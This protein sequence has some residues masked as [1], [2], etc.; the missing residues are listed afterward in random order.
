MAS[1]T[2]TNL[3]NI[4]SNSTTTPMAS[5]VNTTAFDVLI[6]LMALLV[7]LLCLLIIG[8]VLRRI[9]R[10]NKSNRPANRAVSLN[11]L[12]SDKG[13]KFESKSKFY[14]SQKQK[15]SVVVPETTSARKF[16]SAGTSSVPLEI[17]RPTRI[18]RDVSS[19]EESSDED[20]K[21]S[22]N[23]SIKQSNSQPQDDTPANNINNSND[24]SLKGSQKAK[25]TYKTPPLD[26]N[27]HK[28]QVGHAS[29][30]SIMDSDG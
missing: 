3:Y 23:S 25:P 17:Y 5:F 15:N 22:F 4:S 21:S 10:R 19:D 12:E 8:C 26:Y 20:T 28:S 13:D 11:E 2:T 6:G 30:N 1:A 7:A 18:S 16:S 27:P 29:V 14:E 9:T 24:E